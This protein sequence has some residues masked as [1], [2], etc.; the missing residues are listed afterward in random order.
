MGIV[1]SC[2]LPSFD[3]KDIKKYLPLENSSFFKKSI[4]DILPSL[5]NYMKN[6]SKWQPY[7]LFY[8]LYCF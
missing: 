7:Q 5:S 2:L 3:K 8:V 1:N 6:F 4:Y